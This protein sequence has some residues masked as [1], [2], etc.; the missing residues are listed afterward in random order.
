MACF[1]R[2][3]PPP[4]IP[5]DLIDHRYFFQDEDDGRGNYTCGLVR[6]AVADQ[7]LEFEGGLEGLSTP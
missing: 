3:E 2:S 7:L 4:G 5:N 1:S 6:N